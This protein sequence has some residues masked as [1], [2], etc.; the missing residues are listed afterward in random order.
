M[1][2]LYKT[3]VFAL[4]FPCVAYADNLPPP[5]VP[6]PA[7]NLSNT[8]FFDG[9]QGNPEWSYQGYVNYTNADVYRDRHGNK[10]RAFDDP[11]LSVATLLNQVGYWSPETI[12]NS[13]AHL[14][15]GIVVPLVSS[16]TH[17]NPTGA[18]LRN[19]G[20]G[21]GD[22]SIAI[23]AQFDPLWDISGR[24]VYIQR[25]ALDFSLPTGKYDANKDINPGKN[26]LSITPYWAATWMPVPRWELSWRLHYMYNFKN[27]DP[28]SSSPTSFQG[29]SVRDTQAGPAAWLNFAGSYEV[30]PG[31]SIGL[32]GYYFKQ[33]GDDKVN[34]TRLA[35]SREQ[36]LGIGPGVFWRANKDLLFWFNAY[37][38]TKVENRSENSAVV[39]FRFVRPF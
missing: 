9:F 25:F 16:D 13:R 7:V 20:D 27:T 8:S 34:G 23:T 1:K 22:I 2:V 12:G 36:V 24:P 38:E 29:E 30:R 14:G 33:I 37:G 15:F 19:N 4:L 31:L 6:Q 10:N 26:A 18:Q 39:Q 35:D 21:L 17:F 3:C 32:N 28:A 11:R 5:S